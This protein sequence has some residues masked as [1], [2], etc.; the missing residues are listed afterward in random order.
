MQGQK[1]FAEVA[2]CVNVIVEKYRKN[3]ANRLRGNKTAIFIGICEIL[4]PNLLASFILANS[5][6]SLH[7]TIYNGFTLKLFKSQEVSQNCCQ[8]NKTH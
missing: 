1:K 2:D 3:M 7:I 6:L 5:S 8:V 4:K